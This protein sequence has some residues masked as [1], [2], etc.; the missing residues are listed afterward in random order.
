M[1]PEA[2]SRPYSIGMTKENLIG[3]AVLLVV[4]GLIGFFVLK[5]GGQD[6]GKGVNSV[7]QAQIQQRKSILR[8]QL[9]P[10]IEQSTEGPS[11]VASG[12]GSFE[13]GETWRYKNS[14]PNPDLKT[15]GADGEMV[16]IPVLGVGEGATLWMTAKKDLSLTSATALARKALNDPKLTFI[17]DGKQWVLVSKRLVSTS[18]KGR[19]PKLTVSGLFSAQACKGDTAASPAL[20]VACQ[21]RSYVKRK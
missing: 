15:Q 1:P 13:G 3:G 20:A 7:E 17:S 19:G 4:I 21:S 6:G 2:I 8:P 10:L 9:L 12:S 11:V 16:E 18:A 14:W 5:S